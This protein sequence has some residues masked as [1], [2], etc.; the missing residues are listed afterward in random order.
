MKKYGIGILLGCAIL[1]LLTSCPTQPQMYIITFYTGEGSPIDAQLVQEHETAIK[2]V[3][4]PTREGYSFDNWYAESSC[5]TLW[6]FQTPITQNR[7]LYARWLADDHML[8]FAANGGTGSMNPIQLQTD[9]ETFLPANSFT[10]NGFV[11]AGWATSTAGIIAFSN[12]GYYRIGSADVVLYAKWTAVPINRDQLIAMI[13]NEED[14]SDVDTSEITDMSELFKNNATFNQDISAW[15]VGNVTD[16]G[17]MFFGATSFNG[18]I[19]G[20]DVRNVTDMS[21]MFTNASA[22]NQS[23]SAWA[24]GKVADMSLM[25]LGALSFNQDLSDWDVSNVADMN[26]MFAGTES[27]NGDIS[28]WN[29][30]KV[31]DMGSMFNTASAFNQNISSWDVSNVTTMSYMFCNANVFNQDIS[32]WNVFNV[33]DMNSMFYYAASFNQ[34]ISSWNVGSVTDYENFSYGFCPLITAYHP[35]PSWND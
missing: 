30:S 24:V 13:S 21:S 14:V 4:E 34:D 10:R 27:F 6:D 15:D 20:W 19:S 28:G 17:G 2:P 12:A 9:E 25:F 18:D 23:L 16:M 26:A 11:F 31:I 1:F 22:F 8:S 5:D 3:G 32:G 35:D 7:I 33:T 29:V